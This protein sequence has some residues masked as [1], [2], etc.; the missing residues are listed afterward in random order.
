MN[1][2]N[3][4]FLPKHKSNINTEEDL[5]DFL[6][7]LFPSYI[8]VETQDSIF[9]S[10][11]TLLFHVTGPISLSALELFLGSFF[12]INS[13]RVK[14]YRYVKKGSFLSYPLKST[15]L[16]SKVTY[17]ISKA[18]NLL[19]RSYVPDLQCDAYI[20][21]K[22]RNPTHAYG[23][24]L[25]TLNLMQLCIPFEFHDD[26]RYHDDYS[27]GTVV[28]DRK[29]YFYDKNEWE[30]LLEQDMGTERTN[31]LIQKIINYG[32][33]TPGLP[34]SHLLFSSHAVIPYPT[35]PKNFHLDHLE[36]ILS[37]MTEKN[38][39]S[40]RDV[41][42]SYDHILPIEISSTL[43]HFLVEHGLY[44][45][46]S[47]SPPNAVL[48][49]KQVDQDS[50]LLPTAKCFT[51]EQL[52]EYIAA[53]QKNTIIP[54]VKRQYQISKRKFQSIAKRLTMDFFKYGHYY[55]YYHLSYGCSI[56]IIPSVMLNNYYEYFN[57]I[58]SSMCEKIKKTIHRLV[59]TKTTIEYSNTSPNYN[60][61]DG[62]SIIFRNYFKLPNNIVFCVEHIGVD[63][64]GFVRAVAFAKS[65][66]IHSSTM[67]LFCLCDSEEDASFFL[68]T[69]ENTDI[70]DLNN[71]RFIYTFEL[72]KP[73]NIRMA[74][75][76][77]NTFK[78]SNSYTR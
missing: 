41:Y 44:I 20:R 32:N 74:Y 48:S 19:I 9:K 67:F 5:L 68:K 72:D 69:L 29:L 59:G 37:F 45:A 54:Y 14:L 73:G 56:Y 57:P 58:D 61:P 42:A 63:V 40:L 24:G 36:Y 78:I 12:D 27:E 65:R 47:I 3:S 33:A 8:P 38:L 64:A 22:G 2:P 4:F 55:S 16:N 76:D 75:K 18:D 62:P 28:T 10:M 17:G 60:F 49:S 30:L 13:S 77:G 34:T 66:K 11:T 25:S 23:I 26:V 43:K 71:I 46:Y 50:F 1:T 39:S 51:I 15:D 52:K 35:S 6:Q 21:K 31:I 53:V 7:R 70:S